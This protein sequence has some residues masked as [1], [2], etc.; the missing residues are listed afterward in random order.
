MFLFG[1]VPVFILKHSLTSLNHVIII[2]AVQSLPII[3]KYLLNHYVVSMSVFL[4]IISKLK[5]KGSTWRKL[6]KCLRE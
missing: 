6:C 2:E 3:L 5:I 4:K 1:Q